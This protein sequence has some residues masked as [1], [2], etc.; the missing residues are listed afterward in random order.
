MFREKL[1]NVPSVPG[2]TLKRWEC[3]V[4]KGEIPRSIEATVKIAEGIKQ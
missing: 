1:G 2:F 3:L 4:G